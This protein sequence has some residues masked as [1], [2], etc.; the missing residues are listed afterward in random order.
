LTP[1]LSVLELGHEGVRYF[2]NS[3][4]KSD[5]FQLNQRADEDRYIHAV[6]FIAH[7]FYQLQDNLLDTLLTVVPSAQ[8]A[9]QREH[10]KW[11]YAQRQSRDQT[12]GELVSR[13]DNDVFSLVGTHTSEL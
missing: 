9:A 5:V 13:L 1:L 8:N 6:A 2:A 12:L 10:K 4:I 11:A 3:A 7:Q